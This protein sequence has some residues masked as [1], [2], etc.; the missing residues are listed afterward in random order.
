MDTI[1]GIDNQIFQLYKSGSQFF[2]NAINNTSYIL[3]STENSYDRKTYIGND[4]IYGST[5]NA[6]DW[7]YKIYNASCELPS[8]E[9]KAKEMNSIKEMGFNIPM[10]YPNPSN[11]IFNIDIPVI[12]NIKELTLVIYNSN[13]QVVSSQIINKTYQTGEIIKEQ[14]DISNQSNGIYFLSIYSGDKII[15]NESVILNK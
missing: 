2:V 1:R 11:G 5:Y 12:F 3:C 10:L 8:G 14:F 15:Y 7:L 4:G 6:N 13:G 9:R